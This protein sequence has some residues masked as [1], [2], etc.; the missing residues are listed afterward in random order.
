MFLNRYKW[1]KRVCVVDSAYSLLIYF[2]ISSVEDIKS[3]FYFWSKGV[4]EQVRSYFKISSHFYLQPKHLG[5]VYRFLNYHII[6]PIKWSFLL[7]NNIRI[8]GHEHLPFSSSIIRNHTISIIEDGL[9]NYNGVKA[10]PKKH[11]KLNAFLYGKSYINEDYAF[12]EEW[13]Q[14]EY[15]T[16]ID[17]KSPCCRSQK[18]KIIS[19]KGLWNSS[20]KDKQNL[21]LS[22]YDLTPSD[23]VMLRSKKSILL[24]QPYSEDN[25]ITEDEKI[26]VY[27]SK[28][29][30]VDTSSLL[31]KPHPRE[32]TDYTK[33]FPGVSVF[34][35]KVP[36][37][38]LFLLGVKFDKAYTIN[39]TAI[40]NLPSDTKKIIWGESINKKINHFF[41]SQKK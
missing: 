1:V 38:L 36:M 4:P 37:E 8:F 41:N 27:K 3:T 12:K 31:I 16:G 40:Y 29:E 34:T 14:E 17:L 18:A 13:C 28:L 6:F 23:I 22:I 32:T 20:P 24:T 5:R 7:R 19:L 9:R 33:Y 25:V 11:R 35:K 21:I 30:K 26:N 39:S 10:F 2:L 15:L